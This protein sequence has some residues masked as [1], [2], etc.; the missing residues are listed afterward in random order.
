MIIDSSEVEKPKKDGLFTFPVWV[1]L[2]S[3]VADQGQR[4]ISA[5][6]HFMARTNHHG[7]FMTRSSAYGHFMVRISD[8]GDGM[9]Q[10]CDNGD[11]MVRA[12]ANGDR[13]LGALWRFALVF[14]G[15]FFSR[16]VRFERRMLREWI[17]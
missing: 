4:L 16:L 3:P 5:K 7:D 9:E 11:R 8:T 15:F 13:W 10:S 6:L 1:K 12:C 14:D 2:T 17:A